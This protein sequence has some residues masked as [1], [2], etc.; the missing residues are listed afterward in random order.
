VIVKSK[1]TIF[2]GVC[3]S[4]QLETVW[5]LPSLPLTETYGV[6]SPDFP[7]FDQSVQICR[8]CG[9]FQLGQRIDPQFLY[10]DE[11]Y[12][13]KSNGAKREV[14]EQI[15]LRFALS[16][17]AKHNRNILEF[18][19][20]DLSL[21]IHLTKL[22]HAVFA[23][24]PLVSEAPRGIGLRTFKMMVE[25]FLLES[26]ETFDLIVARHT[27]E[28][29]DNPKDLLMKLLNKVSSSGVIILEFPSLDLVVG[30]LRGDAFFHQHYHYYDLASVERLSREVGA[31]VQGFFQNPR[32][33]NGGSLMVAICRE[34]VRPNRLQTTD[35]G[36]IAFRSRIPS[37]RAKGFKHFINNWQNQMEILSSL[38]TENQP[39]FGI[40][41]G[42]MTPVLD[43]HLKGL[44]SRL[45]CILDDDPSKNGTSYRNLN[46]P[47]S[48]PEKFE[49][50]ERFSA[51]V[52]SLESSQQILERA[53]SLGASKILTLPIS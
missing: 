28:H 8:Q 45:P 10:S 5:G 9:H 4:E 41:A 26:D 49:L 20:N 24:D 21:A 40:G 1:T 29:V 13:F 37:D 16:H 19:A 43:Y 51:L 6:Y 17:A 36:K 18:G 50:P 32:G 39:V 2:C 31:E 33:S 15:F 3:G 27:L 42:L 47:I 46:V 25:D 35:L 38:I 52:T 30:S 44:I 23:V 14:E 12:Q 11:N 34:G 48:L 22:G 7:S 53:R